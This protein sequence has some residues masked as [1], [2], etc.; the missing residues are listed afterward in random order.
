ML[1]CVAAAAMF[2]ETEIEPAVP[3]LAW[4]IC[5][6]LT[7]EGTPEVI[8]SRLPSSNR[9]PW[10]CVIWAI[11]SMA[12]SEESICN[13]LAAICSSLKAPVLAASVTRPRISL[14]SELTCPS[15]L[16]A[17]AMSWLARW[18][19][20]IARCTLVISLRKASL[21]IRPAGS[22][23]PVL[24]RKP[25]LRRFNA[26]PSESFDR[27]KFFCAMSELTLVLIRVMDGHSCC[28]VRAT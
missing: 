22:S 25:V 9:R 14:S 28:M 5:R 6:L 10:N 1:A 11:R 27:C 13:W 20:V 12:S 4:S 15:A 8:K 18:L 16:S 17:V 26:R 3:R 23:L 2:T 7:L 21:A 19:L 24:M